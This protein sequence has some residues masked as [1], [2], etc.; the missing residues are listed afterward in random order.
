[1]ADARD[2]RRWVAY[3]ET[4]YQ[5]GLGDLVEYPRGACLDLHQSCEKY[6]KAIL[7]QRQL[8]VA[9][10]HNLRDLLLEVE[11]AL[12]GSSREVLAGR[13]LNLAATRTKYPGDFE[14]PSPNEV[15]AMAEAAAVIRAY[16]RSI[17]ALEE[18]L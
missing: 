15:Q 14:E 4:D 5:P 17:L 6:L 16:A 9:Q 13:L 18:K 12:S 7:V 1:M 8:V 11:P 3:A 2:Y 10:T